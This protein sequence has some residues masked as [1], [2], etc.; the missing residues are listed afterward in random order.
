MEPDEVRRLLC[1]LGRGEF[2]EAAGMLDSALERGARIH[3]RRRPIPGSDLIP[4]YQLRSRRLIARGVHMPGHTA[5]TGVLSRSPE[6]QWLLIGIEGFG[7]GGA[8]FVSE[9]GEP[10]GC[11]AYAD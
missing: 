6:S 3:E 4:I 11:F 10:V 8:V 9:D 5:L 7:T 1:V 2:A